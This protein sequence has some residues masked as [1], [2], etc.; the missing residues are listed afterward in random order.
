VVEGNA[1]LRIKAKEEVM[2]NGAHASEELEADNLNF[3]ADFQILC[4]AET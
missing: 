4:K 2:I 3:D 1:S